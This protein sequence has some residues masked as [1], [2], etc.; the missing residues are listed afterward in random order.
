MIADDRGDRQW[1]N[2]PPRIIDA[3]DF[4][5]THGEDALV[6]EK[7]DH[8]MCR[9]GPMPLDDFDQCLKVFCH[10]ESLGEGILGSDLLQ[11]GAYAE[12]GQKIFVPILPPKTSRSMLEK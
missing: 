9:L 1:S 10:L 5:F 12:D 3:R 4:K 6:H 2:Q 11:I 7:P 8:P